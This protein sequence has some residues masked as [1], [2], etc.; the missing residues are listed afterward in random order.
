[1]GNTPEGARRAVETKKRKLGKDYFSKLTS[2][3]AKSRKNPYLPMKDPE[4]A[5]KL[6]KL[7][8]I[9][10]RAMAKAKAEAKAKE[11]EQGSSPAE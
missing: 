5:R 1:M 11:A 3:A 10:R 8:S 2:K 9:K 7:S 6:A 4:Y